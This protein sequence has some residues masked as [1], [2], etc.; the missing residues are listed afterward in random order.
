VC[1]C[2]FENVRFEGSLII[3]STV[4]FFDFTLEFWT[5]APIGDSNQ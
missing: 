3:L 4:S 2:M 1:C 5:S